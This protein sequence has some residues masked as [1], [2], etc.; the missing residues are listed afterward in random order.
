MNTNKRKFLIVVFCIVI[1]LS[2]TSCSFKKTS[3]GEDKPSKK[4]ENAELENKDKEKIMNEFKKLISNN[5]EPW[6]IVKFLDKNI[7]KVPKNYAMEMIRELEKVQENYI[8]IYSDK[9]FAND[10]QT[11]LAK[12]S[13]KNELDENKIEE[14]EDEE[15]RQLITKILGGKYKLINI[16]NAFYPIIDYEKLKSYNKYLPD[17]MIDFIE[18]RSIETNNPSLIGESLVITWDELGDRII[19]VEEYLGKYSDSIKTEEMLR[20]YGEYLLIYLQGINNTPNYDC[21]TKIVYEDVLD[22]YK[23]LVSENK[24]LITSDIVKKYIS[25]LEEHGNK[26]DED[27][28]S[29]IIDLYNEAISRL[30]EKE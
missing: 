17:E 1:L 16:E 22:S 2:M 20:I 12:I 11:V 10:R 14:I 28:E 19:A 23:K 26:I 27:V 5:K 13:K 7:S 25:I 18:I 21:E 29:K 3:T 30:E 6:E 15:L 8:E 4:I 9:L 24:D